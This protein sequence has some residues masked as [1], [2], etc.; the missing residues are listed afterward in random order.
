MSPGAANF[1]HACRTRWIRARPSATWAAPWPR[2]SA[3]AARRW[4]E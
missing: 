1:I 3:M 2:G 4:V